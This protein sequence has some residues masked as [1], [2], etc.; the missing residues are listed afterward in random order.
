MSKRLLKLT[1]FSNLRLNDSFGKFACAVC[2]MLLLSWQRA[3]P[4]SRGNWIP[5]YEQDRIDLPRHSAT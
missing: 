4:F 3:V 2:L 1:N 5:N